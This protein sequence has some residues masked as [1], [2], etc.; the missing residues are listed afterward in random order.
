MSQRMPWCRSEWISQESV[1]VSRG[2]AKQR[3]EKERQAKQTKAKQKRSKSKCHATHVTCY[4]RAVVSHVTLGGQVLLQLLLHIR[5]LQRAAQIGAE[6]FLM[7]ESPRSLG[8]RCEGAERRRWRLEVDSRHA[9]QEGLSLE[10]CTSEVRTRTGSATLCC[11][12]LA[13]CSQCWRSCALHRRCC[14]PRP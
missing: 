10:T 7:L 5:L 2:T 14:F 1:G 4:P 3:K 12:G 6:L 9:K 13:P 8:K 11:A